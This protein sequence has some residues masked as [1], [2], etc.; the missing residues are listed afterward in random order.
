M[1]VPQEEKRTSKRQRAA[2]ENVEN[3]GESYDVSTTNSKYAKISATS[4]SSSSSSNSSSSASNSRHCAPSQSASA[5]LSTL[6]EVLAALNLSQFLGKFQ[7]E[8]YETEADF[9]ELSS[10]PE[11]AEQVCGVVGMK[12]GHKIRFCRW[13]REKYAENSSVEDSTAAR[14][15][16]AEQTQIVATATT[17]MA[18]ALKELQQRAATAERNQACAEQRA[19]TAVQAVSAAELR[20][21]AALTALA[22]FEERVAG[23]QASMRCS[24]TREP[25]ADPVLCGDGQTYERTAIEQ[26]FNMGGATSPA[27]GEVLT[28]QN[29]LPNI[30][31]RSAIHEAFPEACE[32]YKRQLEERRLATLGAPVDSESQTQLHAAARLN[33]GSRVRDL[34]AAGAA[35]NQTATNGYGVTPLF[36]AAHEGHAEV[37]SLLLE[38]GADVN[39]AMTNDG[40]TPLLIAADEGHAEVLSL[41]L[42]GGADVNQAKTSD[43]TTPLLIAALEGHAEVL[44]FLLEGGADINQ[45]TMDDGTTPLFAAAF[46]GCAEVVSLLLEGGADVNQAKTDDGAS[47]LFIASLHGHSVLVGLFL[48]AGANVEQCMTEVGWSPLLAAAFLGHSEVVKILLEA[49]AEKTTVTTAVHLGIEAGGT[50]LSVAT[51]K[52]HGA[53]VALL[54]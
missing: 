29:L 44:S 20:A 13:V 26:W 8:G 11:Q 50:P 16:S 27:T 48:S 4:L 52:G 53:V 14:T 41:L 23:I 33:Q 30:A 9:I 34:I 21:E 3:D 39:Q 12:S 42:G 18:A 6:S 32:R 31:L 22:A 24:I 1:D 45:A 2:G 49:G 36:V 15:G 7:A 19:V 47:P 37:V 10:S 28:S 43:G 54:M 17:S 40:T 5:S 51:A 46:E 38:G 25:M 35:V